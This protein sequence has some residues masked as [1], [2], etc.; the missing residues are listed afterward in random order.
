MANI[1][2]RGSSIPSAG[3]ASNTAQNRPL[4]NDEIDKNFYALNAA[5]LE[6]ESD[7][8]ATVTARGAAVAEVVARKV[9]VKAAAMTTAIFLNDFI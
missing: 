3:N 7:T 1:F 2:Y 8:L 5:K 6:S 9:P 4:T